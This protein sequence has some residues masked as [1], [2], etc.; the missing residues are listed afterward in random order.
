M[1]ALHAVVVGDHRSRPRDHSDYQQWVQQRYLDELPARQAAAAQRVPGLLQQRQRLVEQIALV[2]QQVRPL[3]RQL[4]A[5][6]HK[7]KQGYFNWLVR[8]FREAWMV[9]DPVV[10]VHPD[11]LLFEAFS[12]DES[13]YGR[14]TVPM[15]RLTATGS[16]VYGTT[17]IDFSAALARE[18]AR[19]RTYRPARLRIG[20]D[21]VA[22]STSAGQAVEKKIDLPATWV[23]G[24][25]Q[26]QSA[27]TFPGTDLRLS[28][29]T[30]ADILSFLRRKREDR[31][32]RSLRFLLARGTKPTVVVEP[33]NVAVTEHVHEYADAFEG[34]I[35]IWGRRR[36]FVLDPLLPHAADVQLRL[37][38]TGMPSYWT[39]ALDGGRL[40]LGLSGWTQNDWARSANF[41]L[42]ASTATASPRDVVLAASALGD[43]LRLGPEELA[44]RTGISREA[45]T[46]ALQRLCREGRAM[47]DHTQRVYRWRQLFPSQLRLEG[48]V[49]DPRTAYA[50]RLLAAGSA[51][52]AAPPARTG[53]VTRYQALVHGERD[54]TVVLDLD[55][56]GRV[57]YAQCTCSDY[58]RDKLRKGA[59]AHILA[60]G[61]LASRRVAAEAVHG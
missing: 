2:E 1:G 56:D 59:C 15:E 44:A 10:S 3:E 36:L 27:A 9:L 23:R 22:L 7:A 13:S 35:R 11:C 4:A 19:I 5:E 48:E 14:V 30:V 47:F 17:N 20:G 39:V 51:A 58:R 29:A 32:P 46:A 50:R 34:A 37:L 60:A 28:A 49:D 6:Y 16:V 41:D 12:L 53:D 55:L 38:G 61:A 24:F 8:H 52:W 57:R 25:L 18:I 40:D 21:A 31:G 43:R 33:W 45:A 54:F 26:V 42:L